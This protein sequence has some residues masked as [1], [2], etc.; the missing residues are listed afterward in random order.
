MT[1][2]EFFTS[3]PDL[4]REWDG[5]KNTLS[6]A[7]L[8]AGSRAKVWWRCPKGHS[9]D[10]AISPAPPWAAAAPTARASALWRGRRTLQPPTRPLPPCGTGKGT[11]P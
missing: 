11:P 10:A 5:E 4:S 7:D 3:D 1:L 8:T 9:Y 2:A 6:P